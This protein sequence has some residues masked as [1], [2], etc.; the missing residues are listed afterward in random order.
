MA[1]NLTID[2]LQL[3]NNADPTRNFVFRTNADGTMTIARGSVGATTQG[4]LTFGAAG[5]AT[6]LGITGT[7]LTGPL[8]GY[9]SGQQTIT[10]GGGLTL[11]HGL[12]STPNIFQ[13]VLVCVGAEHG[14]STGD[15]LQVP[16]F[17][18]NGTST[19]GVGIV[20]DA[21]NLNVRFGNPANGYIIPNKSTGARSLITNTNW[22]LI[23]KA[24]R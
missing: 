19:F 7:S 13:T 8:A 6:L 1:G 12:G 18:D 4:L 3:G 21:T 5:D 17:F 24:W 20:A 2:Q 16:L 11:A 23:I 22:R 15:Q 14:Y 10:S 9:T